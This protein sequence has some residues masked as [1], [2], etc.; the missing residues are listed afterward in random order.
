MSR[1]IPILSLVVVLIVNFL[2][3]FLPI[4]GRTTGEVS[5]AYP[6]LFTPAGFTFSIWG[7]IYVFLITYVIYQYLPRN[8]EDRM[9][10]R[11]NRHFVVNCTAN[12]LWIFAWHYEL[13]T[14]S[15]ILM[16]VILSSLIG[17]YRHVLPGKI[18]GFR[19]KLFVRVPFSLYF[20]WIT[21]AT[22]ANISVEQSVI[23]MDNWIMT[24]T[25]WVF[26]ELALAGA[27]ATVMVIR[28]RDP[29]FGGVVAWAAYGIT[30][31]QTETPEVAGAAAA[32]MILVLVILIIEGIRS[33]VF[34]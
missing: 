6:T 24:K 10:D 1:I 11:I 7:V 19:D 16:A 31:R 23:G 27:I 12:A 32:I 29:I 18:A 17:I 30:E 3:N 21:V 28:Y 2:A 26:V 13:I 4:G 5:E 33:M 14:L 9:F 15:L 25:V 8:R 34:R 20:G 22:L